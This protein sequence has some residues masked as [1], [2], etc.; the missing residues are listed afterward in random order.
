MLPWWTPQTKWSTTGYVV[1]D[2]ASDA[3][4]VVGASMGGMIAQSLAIHHP[5]R[6]RSLTSIMSNPG[7]GSGGATARVLAAFARRGDPGFVTR[8]FVAPDGGWS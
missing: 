8:Q 2:M 6:V 1:D 5:D 7:D 3:A 4:H